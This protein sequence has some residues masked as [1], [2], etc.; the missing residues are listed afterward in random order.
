MKY[1]VYST[2]YEYTIQSVVYDT[3]LLLG[4][5][6]GDNGLDESLLVPV[7]LLVSLDFLDGLRQVVLQ[8]VIARL[9][10]LQLVLQVV[11]AVQQLCG[12]RLLACHPLLEL[13]HLSKTKPLG[14][15]NVLPTCRAYI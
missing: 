1:C 9:H 14:Q 12:F 13:R 5:G 4:H 15:T 3:N 7:Y 6:R 10:L 2:F 8:L 11:H